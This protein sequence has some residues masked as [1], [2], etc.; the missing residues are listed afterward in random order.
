MAV[1]EPAPTPVVPARSSADRVARRV[2]FL[3]PDAPR[4][5]IF[6]AHDAFGKSI[7]VSAVRCLITYIAIPLLGP[8]VGLSG[9]VGPVLGLV[10]GVISM[11][12][13]FFST[14]RFFAAD[15]KW[16]W[17]YAAIGGTIFAFLAVGI[18]IDAVWLVA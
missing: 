17:G 6:G 15:H 16:R 1:T 11:V 5:S 9:A 4:A 18:V 10:L 12:A 14:R 7:A 13:I 2:L 8:V 3:A